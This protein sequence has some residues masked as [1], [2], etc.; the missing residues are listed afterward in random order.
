M[1]KRFIKLIPV[2]LVAALL[3]TMT[4]LALAAPPVQNN[5]PGGI[6]DLTMAEGKAIPWKAPKP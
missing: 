5:T 4:G 6:V 2:V 3:L 1:R